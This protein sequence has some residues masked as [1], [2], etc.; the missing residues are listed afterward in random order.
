MYINTVLYN[1][2]SQ[3]YE[4]TIM[5]LLCIYNGAEW[6]MVG[7]RFLTV[8]GIILTDKQRGK[9]RIIHVVLD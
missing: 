3:G 9:A 1:C 6:W 4:L 5:K 8:I 2:F 7:A